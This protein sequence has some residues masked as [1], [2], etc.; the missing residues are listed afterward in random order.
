MARVAHMPSKRRQ[1]TLWYLIG[2]ILLIIAVN[3]FINQLYAVRLH[4]ALGYGNVFNKNLA[5]GLITKYAG[6]IVYAIL[7]WV[8]LRKF[9]AIMP[10]LPYRTLTVF[11]AL[12]GWGIG[13]GLWTLDPT[14]WFLFIHHAPFHHTDPLFHLDYSFYTYDLPILQGVA[15]RIIFTIILWL[16]TR[17]AWF[18]TT[19]LRQNTVTTNLSA[20]KIHGQLR[21]LLLWMAFLFLLFAAV[22]TLNRYAMAL[23]PGNGQFIFGPDFVTARIS[24][25]IVSWLR[26]LAWLVVTGSVVWMAV[27]V[28]K[29]FPI[30]DGFVVLKARPF[31]FPIVAAAAWVLVLIL[32]AIVNSLV[33]S[34]YVKPNQNTVELPYIQNTINATRYAL[35]I[36]KVVTKP[37]VPTTSITAASIKRDQNAVDNVRINDQNQTTEIYNQLQSFKSYY[38]FDPASVDRYGKSE[39]YIS[40]R[41][42]NVSQLPVQT[43]INKTL[44]Y[45][46]GYGVAVSPVNQFAKDGLPVLWAS[47]TPQQTQ[48]PLPKITQPRIYFGTQGNDVIAPS[49]QGEFDYPAGSNDA[50]SHY[51][52]GY[53]LMI[54]GNR[55]LLTLMQG[56]LRYYTTNQLV[57]KSEFLFDRNIYQRVEDIAPFLRYDHDAFPFIN[58][59]GQ[60]LWM[61]DAYTSTSNIPY[62]EP[63]MGTSYIRNSVKVVINA[64]TGKVTYYVV[65]KSDPILKS[66]EAIYPSL[67]TQNVPSDVRAH[68]RYPMDLF[69][70]QATALTRY[71]MTS[72]SAFY[73]QDDKWALANQIYQQ[74]NVTSRPPVY[75]EIRMP[76][77][78]SPQ[79]VL[80]A[81]F[82]PVN[83]DN[84]NSWLV[85]DNR[86]SDYGK[87][88]LY[89]FSQSQLIFG[90]M[91]A[92]N[93]ID[94]DPSLSA[95]LSL[96]NQQGSQVIRGD[97][98]MVPVGDALLYVEPIYLV[99]NRQ[100]SLPQLER[101]ILDFNEQVYVNSTLSGALNDL[102]RG[103]G[104]SGTV[105]TGSGAGASPGGQTGT[106]GITGAG[107]KGSVA[108]T[109][110]GQSAQK[111]ALI[112]RANA[113]FAEYE[114]DTAKG[115]F[116]AA[117][118]ALQQLGSI[119]KQLTS[120]K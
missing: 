101:V 51:K 21:R 113:L 116:T 32:S 24:I 79:F 57:P 36:D 3:V 93:Q 18:A 56:T 88:S 10:T 84:L 74:N 26:I 63:Y 91:Q 97:L 92:E 87:L 68:F 104:Q 39:V 37:F 40:A 48:A 62:A 118:K 69:H 120:T 70:T 66:Y 29:V 94:A 50:T 13:F 17:V 110:T 14:Q 47:N 76:D 23:W 1:G 12:V 31:R 53:G 81:L 15:S 111:A 85:A 71:H 115:Q 30:T 114:S 27:R 58:N 49:K 86:P 75:Q 98:L 77:Q 43:W 16:I 96:W 46:H 8:S 38:Q 82:T 64:Y 25:P 20:K 72:A 117:G 90:P 83:K 112:N 5:F 105:S 107:G 99:A 22:A 119:L 102:L 42:M 44:V 100:N 34:L 103:E 80:S 9:Q 95:Q 52:G 4:G 35:G 65:D 7:A 67:F 61:M 60:I 73:N 54:R 11:V 109:G 78:T 6:A 59:K 33:N 2:F 19:M 55:W 89:Q 28:E 108:R 45:T 41:E 106:G